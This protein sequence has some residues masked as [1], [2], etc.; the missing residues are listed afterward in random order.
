VDQQ[1]REHGGQRARAHLAGSRQQHQRR[2]QAGEQHDDG[3][4]RQRAH[5]KLSVSGPRRQE[6][7]R[8]ANAAARG[9]LADSGAFG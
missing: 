3:D 6:E 9:S 7:G 1:Q 4:Q 2:D 5:R 8:I